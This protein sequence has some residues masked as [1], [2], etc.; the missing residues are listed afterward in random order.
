[1]LQVV[2]GADAEQLE[3]YKMLRTG[4]QSPNV[5]GGAP[6]TWLEVEQTEVS[7]SQLSRLH[8]GTVSLF[9]IGGNATY[10]PSMAKVSK[11][12]WTVTLMAISGFTG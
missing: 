1:M 10:V 12:F 3:L 5:Q 6:A 2:H 9:P 7:E 8:G 11:V 4:I